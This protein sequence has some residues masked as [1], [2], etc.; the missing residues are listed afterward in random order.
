MGE[1]VLVNKAWGSCIHLFNSPH[2]AVS[3][4]KLKE[5]T[6]CSCH[7]HTQRVNQFYLL[8]GKVVIEQWIDGPESP[9]IPKTLFPGDSFTVP[10]EVWHRF[11]VIESGE[12]IEVYWP[13][14]AYAKVMLDDIVRF[15]EGGDDPEFVKE[16]IS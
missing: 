9:R 13:Y 3:Y 6:R 1:P 7:K 14:N 15:D 11:R 5:G 4:L 8:S 10:I 2:A 16:N 12:M